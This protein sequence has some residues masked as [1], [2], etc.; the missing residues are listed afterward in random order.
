M[1]Q[2]VM[3]H[4]P[5]I[6]RYH[7][8]DDHP[9][10][11]RRIAVTLDLIETLGLIQPEQIIPPSPFDEAPLYRIH[12]KRYV[13]MVKHYSRTLVVTDEALDYGLGTEDVPL[14]SDMHEAALMAVRGTLTGAEYVM[15]HPGRHAVFLGGGLHHAFRHKASGF[16]IYNDAAVAIQYLLDRYDVKVLYIDTDAH[17][18][19]GVQSIFYGEPRVMTVSLHETGKYLFPG[20]G[21]VYERGEGEAV[22]TKINVPLEPFTEDD[23]YLTVLEQ[24]LVPAFEWFRPDVVVSQNGVDAHRFDPL[25]DL[26]LSTYAYRAIP[27]LVHALADAYAGGRWLA[28]GGGGYD[29]WRVVPRAWTY[30]WAEANHTPLLDADIPPSFIERWQPKAPVPLPRRLLDPPF[31]PIPRR[32]EIQEKNAVVLNRVLSF[33]RA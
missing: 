3:I 9:F 24:V 6:F 28:L 18:G 12:G 14:F 5:D 32:K 21:Y 2:A 31:P 26:A 17:H 11:Q 22:G 27:K 7:F 23:D 15:S 33:F 13:E 19:D 10:S 8:H 30:L 1:G 16:C 4:H 29:V 25:A 20:T